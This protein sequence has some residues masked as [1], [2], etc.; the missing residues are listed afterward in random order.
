MVPTACYALFHLIVEDAAIVLSPSAPATLRKVVRRAFQHGL[1][2]ATCKEF[3][4]ANAALSK[5]K[6]SALPLAVEA[7]LTF[8][9]EA[10]L[11]V[12]L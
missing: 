12:V 10:E 7:M 4:Q 8:P 1:R 5:N 2:K 6:R 9:L 11:I 3:A